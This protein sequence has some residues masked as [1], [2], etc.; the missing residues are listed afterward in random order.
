[1]SARSEAL[2][3][4]HSQPGPPVSPSLPPTHRLAHT[5]A[6]AVSWLSS[7]LRLS[8]FTHFPRLRPLCLDLFFP[9]RSR[10]VL[11]CLLRFLSRPL[12]CATAS[13]RLFPIVHNRCWGLVWSLQTSCIRSPKHNIFSRPPEKVK[14]TKRKK[15][16]QLKVSILFL[17]LFAVLSCLGHCEVAR[18]RQSSAPVS[19]VHASAHK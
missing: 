3:G 2:V 15:E 18:Q 6:Q 11:P 4:Y 17:C 19:H 5:D 14:A 13:P 16:E 8:G 9:L 10:C 12:L 1:M 7:P